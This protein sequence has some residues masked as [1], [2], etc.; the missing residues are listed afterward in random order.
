MEQV[1][2][3]QIRL[4]TDC[5]M[6]HNHGLCVVSALLETDVKVVATGLFVIGLLIVCVSIL[7]CIGI[8][9]ENRCF[10]ALVSVAT[11]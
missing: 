9:L 3:E 10:I 7:G 11:I 6:M 1:V 8:H 2:C 5:V 4:S